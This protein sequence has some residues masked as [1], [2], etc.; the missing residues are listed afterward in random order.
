LAS[1]VQELPEFTHTYTDEH[2]N[3]FTDGEYQRIYW[4][5]HP[6][7]EYNKMLR[8]RIEAKAAEEAPAPEP[9]KNKALRPSPGGD[10]ETPERGDAV[11]PVL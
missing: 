5:N 7:Q 9:Q 2:G 3:V 4:A 6:V 10:I 11:V 1:S 8:E